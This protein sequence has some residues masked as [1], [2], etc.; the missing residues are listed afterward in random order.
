MST[1]QVKSKESVLHELSAK[2]NGKSSSRM[3]VSFKED[4]ELSTSM[5]LKQK[6]GMSVMNITNFP[7]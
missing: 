7:Y 5:L 6:I 1:Y 3:I 4:L 2:R